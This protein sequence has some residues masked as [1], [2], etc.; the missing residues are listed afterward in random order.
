MVEAICKKCGKIIS[1]ITFYNY[2]YK[3]EKGFYYCSWTCYNH[4][5]DGKR[6]TKPRVKM[7]ELHSENGYL[8][9]VFTSATDAA[10]NTGYDASKIRDACREQKTYMGFIWKYRE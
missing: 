9:K 4:R 6:S 7:V 5:N 3:D 10:E 2:A 8:L 1:R